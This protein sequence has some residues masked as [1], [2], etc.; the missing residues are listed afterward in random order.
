VVA[1]FGANSAA[2]VDYPDYAETVARQVLASEAD[3]GI[4]VCKVVSA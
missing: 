4:L 2:S 3:F 1:D